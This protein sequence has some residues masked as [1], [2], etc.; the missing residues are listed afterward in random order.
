MNDQGERRSM[1]ALFTGQ[2]DAERAFSMLSDS[3]FRPEEMG[4]LG[5][6][7]VQGPDHA[8]RQAAGIGGGAV[9]GSLAG[10]LLGA[11]A[12]SAIPGI[13]PVITAG[14]LLPIVMGA[15]TGGAT[16]GTVGSLLTAAVS[17][18]E[19]LYFM[20]EVQAGRCLLSVTTDRAEAARQLLLQHVAMEVVYVGKLSRLEVCTIR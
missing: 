13:G 20:Q 9:A 18:D 10:G 1:V 11:A 3:G 2:A 17:K 15:I 7:E 19:L 8:R 16:G 4:F 5:P 14:A 12:V 6:H